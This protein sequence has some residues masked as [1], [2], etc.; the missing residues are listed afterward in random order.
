MA[1]SYSID[2]AHQIVTI[3]GDYTD[4]QGWRVLLETVGA[5]P[6]YQRGFGFI[7][8]LRA[9]EH[10]VDAKTVIAIVAVVRE[11]WDVL[12]VRRAAMVTRLRID[13]PATV[14]E[15]LAEDHRVSLRAF[16]SYDEAVAWVRSG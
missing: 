2:P 15:A 1:L 9:S 16:T 7:R 11:F 4:A 14:A 3:T 12:G 10:P 13:T 5:D 8:D 6:Q